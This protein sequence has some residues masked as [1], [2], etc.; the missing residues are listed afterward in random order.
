MSFAQKT[1][2]F[3]GRFA[4]HAANRRM[5]FGLIVWSPCEMMSAGFSTAG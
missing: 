2:V 3:G 1:A 4:T 5:F